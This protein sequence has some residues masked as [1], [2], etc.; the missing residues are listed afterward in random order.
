MAFQPGEHF[1]DHL[2]LLNLTQ[3]QMDDNSN[4]VVD[5]VLQSPRS[6]TSPMMFLQSPSASKIT[7][8]LHQAEPLTVHYWLVNAKC[9]GKAVLKMDQKKRSIF[10]ELNEQIENQRE[11]ATPVRCAVHY[12][13]D[14]SNQFAVQLHSSTGLADLADSM[15]F[16]NTRG[17]VVVERNNL[18]RANSAPD[19]EKTLID[20]SSV[21]VVY[22]SPYVVSPIA[23]FQ[24]P[25]IEAISKEG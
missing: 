10:P 24:V 14:K 7:I 4:V 23:N 3:L 2:V 6:P 9:S 25:Q 22:E 20:V 1:N 16:Y 11:S 18:V 8:G 13:T 5:G 19:N 21:L 12:T 15:Y 17:V